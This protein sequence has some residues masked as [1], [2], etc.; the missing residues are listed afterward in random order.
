MR[1]EANPK[2][3]NQGGNVPGESKYKSSLTPEVRQ[4]LEKAEEY[5]SQAL[6][7][8]EALLQEKNPGRLA[9]SYEELA[10]AYL[11]NG[12]VEEAEKKFKRAVVL[13]HLNKRS[14]ALD[15]NERAALAASLRELGNFYQGQGQYDNAVQVFNEMIRVFNEMIT[16]QRAISLEGLAQQGKALANSYIDLGQIHLASGKGAMADDAFRIAKILQD[17]A[18]LLQKREKVPA[19]SPQEK[20]IIK[21]LNVNLDELGDAY[22]KLGKLSDAEAEA[23]Y[24]TALSQKTAESDLAKSHEKLAALYQRQKNY[25]KAEESYN[26]LLNLYRDKPGSVA[27]AGALFKM[28]AFYSAIPERSSDAVSNYRQALKIFHDRGAWYDENFILFRLTKIYERQG[29]VPER[30]AALKE[31]A[32]TLAGYVAQLVAGNPIRPNDPTKLVSEYLFAVD[33]L[34]YFHQGK[35]D[36]EV[37]ATYQRAFEARGYITD[38]IRNDQVLKFYVAVLSD[39]QALLNRLPT[40]KT[41]AAEVGRVAQGFRDALSKAEEKKLTA[42]SRTAAAQ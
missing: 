42:D 34:G 3:G 6:T 28:A 19:E 1:E 33:A 27:Y 7:I 4:A 20:T 23:F 5:F 26:R 25:A 12:K 37:E 8:Q 15:G 31:R 13:R 17:T 29:Q 36:A 14:S 41:L 35:K 21:Q 11:D 30:A 40:K 18:L 2:R 10:R 39:Y 24:K 16:L 38:K 22:F 32:D 9:G